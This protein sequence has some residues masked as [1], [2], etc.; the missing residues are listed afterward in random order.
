MS[1]RFIIP[2]NSRC[3]VIDTRDGPKNRFQ[4]SDAAQ[5]VRLA[6]VLNSMQADLE[7]MWQCCQDGQ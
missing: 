2:P 5:A 3:T 6:D 4:L 7:W 1:T